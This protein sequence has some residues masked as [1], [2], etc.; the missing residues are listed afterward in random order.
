[1]AGRRN[2]N[3][4]NNTRMR[5]ET[6]IDRREENEDLKFAKDVQQKEKE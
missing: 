1:M 5:R 4:V 3:D 6:E 2:F